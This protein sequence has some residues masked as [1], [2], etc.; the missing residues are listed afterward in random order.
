MSVLL[1]ADAND[2]IG[3]G[4]VMRSASLGL[5]LLR[6]GLAVILVSANIPAPL[7][8]SLRNQGL[9]FIQ[10][11][12]ECALSAEADA[13]ATRKVA[14]DLGGVE[15]VVVDHY[16]RDARWEGALRQER[17]RLM[18][19]DD[20]AN[21]PHDCDV[22]LD[23]GMQSDR[24]SR[25]VGLVPNG[26]LMLLGPEFA[27][28]RPEF[29]D[30]GLL[31]TRSG[32]ITNLLI[33]LGGGRGIADEILKVV[34]AVG[35]LE[36]PEMLTTLVLGSIEFASTLEIEIRVIA[37]THEM[38]PLMRD[39]DLAIGTCGGAGW[40]RCALG[41]PALTVLSAENQRDDSIYLARCG[42][43]RH[44]GDA[45]AVSVTMW[46]SALSELITNPS[47]VESMGH[48]ASSVVA[49]R[50]HALRILEEVF[51]GAN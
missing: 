40:E 5:R 47:A 27:L 42:A 6:R 43:I 8:Q 25:Y 46:Q 44:L 37:Q 20:L 11:P 29:D 22:L 16:D 39:A 18:V 30:V 23:P 31:R 34:S 12:A 38:A 1:R 2:D 26:T 50:G 3:V 7:L 48:A 35:Q 13:S 17:R 36:E 45:G 9:G 21:R 28:L 32:R 33:Y 15:W 10:L 24:A 14:D 51:D 49:G 19:I 41:L 4:H